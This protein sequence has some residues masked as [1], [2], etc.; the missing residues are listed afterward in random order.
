MHLDPFG[1]ITALIM[2]LTLLVPH[3]TFNRDHP[4]RWVLFLLFSGFAMF[5]F[6]LMSLRILVDDYTR[7]TLLNLIPYATPT[8]AI[9]YIIL[10]FYWGQQDR[11]KDIELK[12]WEL[13]LREKEL[14]LKQAELEYQQER[15]KVI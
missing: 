14:D 13:K 15:N 4:R 5:I 3:W 7:I 9:P 8:A 10:K 6:S 11:A 1:I 2:F 12:E